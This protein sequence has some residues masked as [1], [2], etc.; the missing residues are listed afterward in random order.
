MAVKIRIGNDIPVR[1][2]VTRCGVPEDLSGKTLRLW[3]RTAYV[4]TEVTEFA[5][6][7]NVI[8]WTYPGA[9]QK[10]TGTYTFTLVE[11]EGL[12]D[13]ATID[14]CDALKLVSCSCAA[15]CAESVEVSTDIAVPANGR[16]PVLETGRTETLEPGSEATA[17]VEPSGRDDDGNPVYKLNL[18]LPEGKPGRT[19]VFVKGDV[20]TGEAGSQASAAVEPA[21]EDAQGNPQYRLRRQHGGDHHNGAPEDVHLSDR[22]FGTGCRGGRDGR[23]VDRARDGGRREEHKLR[24]DRIDVDGH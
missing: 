14:A 3:M 7:G 11:N 4:E 1:W 12:G 9:S 10:A 13:M 18:G 19:P 5:V 16:T 17:A 6:N 2:T 22:R 23:G 15:E 20:I 8:S 21:G 24:H